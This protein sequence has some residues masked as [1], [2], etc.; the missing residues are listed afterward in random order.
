MNHLVD[1]IK[2][3]VVTFFGSLA[4]GSNFLV[5]LEEIKGWAAAITVILGAPTAAFM[6][7]YWGVKA[8]REWR[9]KD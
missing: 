4:I 8:Y 6:C 9:K 5:L 7:A 2:P 3:T 1:H